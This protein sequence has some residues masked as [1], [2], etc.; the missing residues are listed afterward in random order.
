M[1]ATMRETKDG[2]ALA[3]RLAEW[4]DVGQTAV[5]VTPDGGAD[6]VVLAMVKER[7][8]DGLITVALLRNDAGRCRPWFVD[9]HVR[10]DAA[11][12]APWPE[13]A[14]VVVGAATVGDHPWALV[15]EV[16]KDGR[17]Q[18]RTGVNE[19]V[20]LRL[21]AAE[22]A[23]PAWASLLHVWL[24]AGL[25]LAALASAAGHAIRRQTVAH[26][27]EEQAVLLRAVC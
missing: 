5:A 10:V 15:V 7:A 23:W 9:Q 12:S 14:D 6:R 19:Y 3:R 20:S 2:R 18:L 4:L 11:A 26:R 17:I 8:A 22:P 21:V 16:P 13:V 1:S 24:A 25:P 27:A